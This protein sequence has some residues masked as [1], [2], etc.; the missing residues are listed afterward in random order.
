MVDTWEEKERKSNIEEE[1]RNFTAR[2]CSVEM[3]PFLTLVS[4]WAG[5]VSWFLKCFSF[6]LTSQG[7]IDALK[8]LEILLSLWKVTFETIKSNQLLRRSHQFPQKHIYCTHMSLS[9]RGAFLSLNPCDLSWN[10]GLSIFPISCVHHKVQAPLLCKILFFPFKC[11]NQ[12]P[13][14]LCFKTVARL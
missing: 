8:P 7:R 9:P 14:K 13:F 1:S 12:N 10:A 6:C 11:H 2:F 3:R 4:L 5:L